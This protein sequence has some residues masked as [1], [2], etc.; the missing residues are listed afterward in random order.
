M[1]VFQTEQERKS[2][3]FTALSFLLLMLLLFI[4]KFGNDV[5]LL[6][7]EGGGGGGD[8][9]VNFGD[10]DVG[11]GDNFT[12]MESARSAPKPTPQQPVAASEIITS[13]ADDAPVI[14]DIRKPVDK[15]KKTEDV[16]PITK[17]VVKPQQPSNST[18]NALDDLLKG[19][20]KSGDGNDN[21]GGNK[22]KSYGNPNDR[23]YN[24]G[25]GTGTGSGGGDGSGT[26]PGSGSGSGGGSGSGRG[27]GVGNYQL[28][29]RKVLSK[30]APNYT[31]NEQGTVA[32][33]ITVN[34]SGN[35][36]AATTG[37]RGTT[38]TAQCL[39]EQA[40]QAALSTRFDANPGAANQVGKIIYSFRL[41]Q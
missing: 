31:C 4:F 39:A 11:M 16:K 13:E 8:I 40:K 35:V 38:N 30:P 7:L 26:G 1:A 21:V 15:P 37:V 14:A 10:S 9:A 19:S 20:D 29:G 3:L 28:A 33:E 36:V 25:G 18:K 5:V 2:L 41:T 17:P 24:G 23:G 12:S 27:T 22:G 34:S 32:V 6:D